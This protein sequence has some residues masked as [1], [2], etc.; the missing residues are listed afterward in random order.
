MTCDDLDPCT[1]DGCE[2]GGCV[3]PPKD[4]DDDVD[5][6]ADSC[7]QE[8]GE[9]V[10]ECEPTGV[11]A[12]GEP[13]CQ[14]LQI[15]TPNGDPTTTAGANVTN[16]RTYSTAATNP[17]L[18]VPCAASSISDASKLRWTITDAGSIRAKW[19][20][21]VAGDE[22]T[23]T[24]LTPTATY[25]GMPPNFNDFGAKTITLT[26]DGSAN[27]RDT[28]IVEVFYPGTATNHPGG[29]PAFPNW[30]QY[31]QQNEGG[32]GYTYGCLDG[33][34]WSNV[35]IPGS[36]H[37]CDE[38][39]V[40]D[41]YIL[42]TVATGQLQVTGISDWNRYYANFLGVVAHERQHAN[43]DIAAGP[44]ADSD[45]DFLGNGFE[46]GTSR[47]DPHDPCSALGM[48]PCAE[49]NDSEAYAGGPVEEGGVTN[50]NTSRDWA[51]PGS[52]HR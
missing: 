30:F 4:C 6:T 43:G 16:E 52:N 39:Y 49:L 13:T 25:T 35:G 8:T 40:G 27:C 32:T 1:D 29:N 9:C 19:S 37:I 48:T 24:G 45:S 41:K 46:L 11:T 51:D 21:H 22:Y 3:Y 44:P 5:C 50:A 28:Q 17:T 26:V 14:A 20:P 36:T 31:Y 2:N 23:G 47:P 18:T 38:A 10:H 15:T 42:T 33:T 7:D 12:D 34:S